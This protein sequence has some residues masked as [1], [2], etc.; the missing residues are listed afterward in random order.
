MRVSPTAFYSA[1]LFALCLLAAIACGGCSTVA[2]GTYQSVSIITDPPG[3]SVRV[4]GE[5][6][7]VS[8]ATIQLPRRQDAF[9]VVTKPGYHSQTLRIQS[10]V[11]GDA[12]GALIKGGIVGG[13]VDMATGA[14][15]RLV[16]DRVSLS[17]R[18]MENATTE[19]RAIEPDVASVPSSDVTTKTKPANNDK[20]AMP[21]LASTTKPLPPGAAER[22]RQLEQ[23][24]QEQLITQAEYDAIRAKIL[25]SLIGEPAQNITATATAAASTPGS[26]EPE[27]K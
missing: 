4:L 17:L 19:P 5:G 3:A 2:T 14:A 11:D 6:Q 16:P 24:R 23:M 20:P 13:A 9:V 21:A 7:Y 8:P 10:V 1:A 22:L 18:A 15:F 25:A 12:A 27:D 26:D